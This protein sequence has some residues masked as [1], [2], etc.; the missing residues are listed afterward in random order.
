MMSTAK[1]LEAIEAGIAERGA[2]AEGQEDEPFQMICHDIYS[3]S[4]A[5]S[6]ARCS[7]K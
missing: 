6:R 4:R 7:V 3:Q 5:K 1:C 2:E